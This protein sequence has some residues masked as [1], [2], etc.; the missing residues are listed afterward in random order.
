MPHVPTSQDKENY[1]LYK[2]D[3]K[4]FF[5]KQESDAKKAATKAVTKN[6]DKE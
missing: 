1:E 3:P 4:K 5:N 2:K 6:E